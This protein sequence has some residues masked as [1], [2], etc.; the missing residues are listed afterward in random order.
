M[1]RQ[2]RE[3]VREV[4]VSLC[5]YIASHSIVDNLVGHWLGTGPNN[6]SVVLAIVV[7][8]NLCYRLFLRVGN[9]S[10]PLEEARV[11]P[12][13]VGVPLRVEKARQALHDYGTIFRNS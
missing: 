9:H 3:D 6:P 8:V 4:V 12:E 11:P 1:Q 5:V 10:L 13:L 7:S 2:E